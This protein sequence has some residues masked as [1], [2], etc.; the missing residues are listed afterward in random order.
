MK[1]HLLLFLDVISSIALNG[2]PINYDFTSSQTQ[3]FGAAQLK[4]YT[5]ANGQNLWT[6]YAGDLN[7]D[8]II[9]STD[10]DSWIVLPAILNTYASTDGNLDGLVQTSD[11]DV[12]F[13]NKAK[14]GSLEIQY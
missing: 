5:Q 4:A 10:F 2:N 11:Y 13:V 9:Q 12:W 6:R 14:V 7:Q 8:G 1:H 3:A